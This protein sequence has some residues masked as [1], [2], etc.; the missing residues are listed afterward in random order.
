MQ[1][2]AMDTAT[3]G[4]SV[5]LWRNGDIPARRS[6][7]MARG[8]SEA[9]LPMI[10]EV[11]TEAG[12]AAMD[13]DLIAVTRGPGAFTGLRIGL[14]AARAM[15][16]AAGVPCLGVDTTDVI[17][18]G[19][20]GASIPGELL[21]VLDTKRTDFYAQKFS[22]RYE[23]LGPPLAISPGALAQFVG[24]QSADAP[25]MVVGD[26]TDAAL[27]LLSDATIVAQAARASGLPDAVHLA[28]IAAQRWQ[29]GQESSPPMPLYLR[30]ADAK[31]PLNGG[32]LRP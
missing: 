1:I 5:A 21:V 20:D 32:R 30:P 19:V 2:L 18:R 11:L 29:P 3:A 24:P 7:A 4:C 31:R 8:Q 28:E 22:C 25:L 12:I 13:L 26:A 27:K 15:A 17:A 10:Q 6:Q 9:L 16:L 23:P 14:A